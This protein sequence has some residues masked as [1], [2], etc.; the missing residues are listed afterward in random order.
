MLKILLHYLQYLLLFGSTAAVQKEQIT[1]QKWLALYPDGNEA[2]ADIRRSG[3]LKL[4]PVVVSDNPD[5]T[6]PTTQSI[7]RINFMLSETI[8]NGPA[9]EAAIPLLGGPDKITTPLWWDKN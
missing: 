2:W 7:K 4:Y 5:I 3:A 9:V 6:D 8:T 1:I